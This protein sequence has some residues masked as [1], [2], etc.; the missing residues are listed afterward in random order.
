MSPLPYL[1]GTTL[2]VTGPDAQSV[3]FV[4]KAAEFSL[5]APRADDFFL[6]KPGEKWSR[7]INFPAD[8]F[9]WGRYYLL[10]TGLYRIKATYQLLGETNSP[11]ARGSWLGKVTSNTIVLKV[12]GSA[13]PFGAEVKGLRSRVTLPK[14]KFMVGEAIPVKYAV[15]NVSRAQ[16]T[17]WHSGFWPNHQIIVRD[18]R[19]KEPPLTAFGRQCEEAFKRGVGGERGKNAPWPL[20]A[21]A[22]DTTEGNYDL[23]KLYHLSKPG[24]YTVQYVYEETQEGGWKG[25]LLSSK[26]AFEII[27]RK[28]AKK[29]GLMESKA[30]RLKRVD[31]QAVVE[32]QVTV[33]GPGAQQKIDLGLR[34]TNRS[35]K[36][37]LLNFFDTLQP[38]LKSADGK[39]VKLERTV[40]LRTA[41]PFPVLVSPGQTE[42]IWY[43]A[44]LEWLKDGK[45]LRL[46]CPDATGFRWFFDGLQP[47]KYFLNFEYENTE[48]AQA[49]NYRFKSVKLKGDQSFWFGKVTTLG[50]EFEIV[51]RSKD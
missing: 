40:R 36:T 42:T 46:I 45:S 18:A 21:G 6:L 5:R 33:P 17:L 32:N 30:V 29:A 14:A 13:N 24:R 39:S 19:D 3:R 31:F 44:H 38:G 1:V 34:I 25:R 16:Q 51:P 7:T 35:G 28:A 48:K 12:E 15:K 10:K 9:S 26:V 2:S 27:P 20:R 22:E 11:L 50:A 4:R 37:L 43:R 47:G 8:E 41:Y 23:S 49:G